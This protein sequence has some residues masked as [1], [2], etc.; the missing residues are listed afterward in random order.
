MEWFIILVIL[1]SVGGPIIGII[2]WIVV[3]R[4][5]VNHVQAFDKEQ[6]KLM[7]LADQYAKKA[8]KGKVPPQV[9]QQMMNQLMNMRSHVNQMNGLRRQQ[10]EQCSRAGI[11]QL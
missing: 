8:K 7:K 3:I 11:Y 6:R 5:A 2:F 9:N 10:Y 1:L 4:A